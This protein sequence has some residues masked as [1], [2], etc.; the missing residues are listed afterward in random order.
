MRAHAL[1]KLDGGGQRTLHIT[2]IKWIVKWMRAHRQKFKTKFNRKSRDWETGVKKHQQKCVTGVFVW[3]EKGKVEQIFESCGSLSNLG[4]T[5]LIV[6]PMWIEC[7]TN[8]SNLTDRCTNKQTRKKKTAM[9]PPLQ[10][11][12]YHIQQREGKKKLLTNKY[13]EGCLS[14]GLEFKWSVR[15]NI[16]CA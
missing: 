13:L 15:R 2:Y 6:V 1:P 10:L 11:S 7:K 3:K 12:E 9:H 5:N 16:K 8:K 14:I 4:I